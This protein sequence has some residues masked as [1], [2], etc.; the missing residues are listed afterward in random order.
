MRKPLRQVSQ[1]R[2]HICGRIVWRETSPEWRRLESGY[3]EETEH[4]RLGKEWVE[5][6]VCLSA[7]AVVTKYYRLDGLYNRNV[8]SHSWR[9]EVPGQGSGRFGFLRGLSPWL[10]DGRVL[11]ASSHGLS[12]RC[13][14]ASL[15]PDLLLL[16]RTLV[17]LD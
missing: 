15:G 7:Y 12:P 2:M 13:L 9:L 11:S 4:A 17:M 3:W 6:R 14:C 5:K 8:F 10:T 1:I 16:I